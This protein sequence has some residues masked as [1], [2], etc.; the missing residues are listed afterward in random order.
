MSFE[1]ITTEFFQKQARRLLKKYPSLRIE[2]QSLK[3]NLLQN[4]TKGT[5]IGMGCYKIRLAIASKNTGK[6]G[7]ARVITYVYIEGEV[8]FLLSVYDK[9][10]QQNISPKQLK[11]L[12]SLLEKE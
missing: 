9:S 2:L 1:I 7:G 11:L 3:S 4:P 5:S 6:S 8:I 10:E 12:L